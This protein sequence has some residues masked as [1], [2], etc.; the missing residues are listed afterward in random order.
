VSASLVAIFAI[1]PDGRRTVKIVCVGG[2]PAGLYFAVLA[3][4]QSAGNDVTVVERN[5][6]DA[7]HS[8]GVTFGE[9]FLDDLHRS[10][11]QSA[12]AVRTAA[13]LWS[14]QVVRVGGHRP[15][16]LGGKYGY[17]IGRGRLLEILTERCRRLGV[18]F[19]FGRE[20]DSAADLDAD[21]VVAADGVG[22]R[23]RSAHAGHF[24]TTLEQGENRYIWLGTSRLS[25]VFTFAFEP[26]PAGWVW[27][28]AYPS[29]GGASTCIIECSPRT[30]AG[31]E[32]DRMGPSEGLR[33]LERVFAG[34]LECHRLLEPPG[35]L[36]PAPW[37]Q[38]REVRNTT[39]RRDNMVLVGDAAHT[40][41]FGIGSGTVL[42]V[43]DA[44]ALAE[45]VRDAPDVATAVA[46][47]D[48]RRRPELGPIQDMAARNMRWF[49]N[50]D[51]EITGGVDEDAVR[52][53]Y[54]LLDR[55]G[56]QAPWRYRL[57]KATQIDGVRQAR[58]TVTSAR[59][60]LR[61]LRRG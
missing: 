4:L 25:A 27:F 23:L 18:R 28:Y 47:Y 51:E 19:E 43:Q 2:G 48:D 14:E 13:L 3:A 17:S 52:F 33:M 49:E 31:L 5:P 16:H 35:G 39:W 60:S 20:V 40:T 44:I 56:D 26:T 37:R 1:R 34:P 9:D 53:A 54:S 50:V 61:G 11:P 6:P 32:L 30:W 22:S 8:W 29:T 58:R 55:R 24:G 36:G 7:T 38:F 59:R 21:L 15:V 57:H 10:D 46:V 12:R 41:H 45:A 42:A